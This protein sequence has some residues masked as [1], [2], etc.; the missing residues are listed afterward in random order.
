MQAILYTYL[1]LLPV[2]YKFRTY[3][4]HENILISPFLN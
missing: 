1:Q 4:N 3:D 2:V